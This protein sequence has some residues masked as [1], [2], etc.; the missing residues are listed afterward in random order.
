M[1]RTTTAR[2]PCC[3]RV[4][5][6]FALSLPEQVPKSCSQVIFPLD[7]ICMRANLEEEKV[8]RREKERNCSVSVQQA[9]GAGCIAHPA[10]IRNVML[11]SRFL[12]CVTVQGAGF[13]APIPQLPSLVGAFEY[14]LSIL[15]MS[16]HPDLLGGELLSSFPHLCHYFTFKSHPLYPGMHQVLRQSSTL[17]RRSVYCV[18]CARHT[19]DYHRCRPVPCL[20]VR[21]NHLLQWHFPQPP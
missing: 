11:Y 9:G 2:S 17:H 5:G 20:K 6:L 14:V 19:L 15:T 7:R 1:R 16:E 21:T 4:W 8:R 12:D 10:A 3:L 13:C 18:F